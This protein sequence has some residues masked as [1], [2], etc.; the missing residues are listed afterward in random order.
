MSNN[1]EEPTLKASNLRV[2]RRARGAEGVVA[3]ADLDGHSG[4]QVDFGAIQ[5]IGMSLLQISKF[6]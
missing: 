3:A 5:F 1:R 2:A 6:E 4:G